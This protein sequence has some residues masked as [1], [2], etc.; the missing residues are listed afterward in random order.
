MRL[1][2]DRGDHACPCLVPSPLHKTRKLGVGFQ[3]IGLDDLNVVSRSEDFR[4]LPRSNEW[5]RD[6]RVD[7]GQN[8]TQAAS[9]C[10]HLTNTS[11]CERAQFIWLARLSELLARPREPMANDE[12]LHDFLAVC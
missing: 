5:A 11:L 10:L 12:K 1:V 2:A 3:C 8:P 4:G 6:E 9:N 7:T